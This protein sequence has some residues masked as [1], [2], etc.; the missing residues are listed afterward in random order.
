MSEDAASLSLWVH[1]TCVSVS[2]FGTCAH[3]FANRRLMYV[4]T[5]CDSCQPH[6]SAKGG[7]SAARQSKHLCWKDGKRRC[8]LVQTRVQMLRLAALSLVAS[9]LTNHSQRPTQR[10][11]RR[12][13][14]HTCKCS[15]CNGHETAG[16]SPQRKVRRMCQ[17]FGL[18]C[19]SVT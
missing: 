11:V 6:C 15:T 1:K 2:C 7:A 10:A 3:L 17:H 16:I 14:H 18:S 8:S 12:R 13:R 4:Q 9:L 19:T 5:S